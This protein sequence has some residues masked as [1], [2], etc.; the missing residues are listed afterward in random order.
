MRKHEPIDACLTDYY[1][2]ALSEP[3]RIVSVD[4]IDDILNVEIYVHTEQNINHIVGD[5]IKLPLMYEMEQQ[6]NY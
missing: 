3:L 5:E 1:N 2:C 6:F 4:E